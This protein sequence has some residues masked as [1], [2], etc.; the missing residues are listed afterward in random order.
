MGRLLWG[1]LLLSFATWQ[2]ALSQEVKE[3]GNSGIAISERIGLIM[4]FPASAIAVVLSD[5]AD[6]KRA[7]E[8]LVAQGVNLTIV[9]K[10]QDK[11]VFGAGLG[12]FIAGSDT[13]KIRL[14][15]GATLSFFRHWHISPTFDVASGDKVI[16]LGGNW[17]L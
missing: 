14:Y 5:K 1:L 12:G 16:L 7:V 9:F 13:D 11:E 6:E 2:P 4:R 8:A 15:T 10:V 17:P 3:N